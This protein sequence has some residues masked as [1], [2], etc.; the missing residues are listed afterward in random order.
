MRAYEYHH[1]V[2]FEETNL[3]GNVYYTNHVLWQGRCREMFLREHAPDIAEELTRDLRLVTTSCSCE[4]LNELVA[5]DQVTV[6]MRLNEITQNAISLGFEYLR[7][8]G[9]TLEL[10]ARGDQRIVCMQREN[11]QIKPTPIPRTLRQA[12]QAYA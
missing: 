2:C 5:F 4:Y 6:R 7:R 11:D 9:E 12:L 8:N 1:V 3:V 10:V